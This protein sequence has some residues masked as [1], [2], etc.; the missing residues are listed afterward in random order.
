MLNWL[1]GDDPR[2]GCGLATTGGGSEDSFSF[3]SL[4]SLELER[5][6]A[7]CVWDEGTLSACLSAAT[8]VPA[9]STAAVIGELLSAAESSTVRLFESVRTT[10]FSHGTR[11]STYGK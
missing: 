3:S 11:S 1:P 5:F 7:P 8:L 9:A 6:T 4:V 10:L 2:L